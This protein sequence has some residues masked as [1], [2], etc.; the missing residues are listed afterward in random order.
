MAIICSSIP[1]L[2]P[3]VSAIFPKLLGKSS[4]SNSRSNGYGERIDSHPMQSFN[5][6]AK[7]AGLSTGNHA[8]DI[9][10]EQTFDVRDEGDGGELG[11][12]K[13]QPRGE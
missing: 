9:Y 13:E 6:S 11:D 1:A 12:G 8:R 4:L 3:L 7:G 2:E 5:R 10:V